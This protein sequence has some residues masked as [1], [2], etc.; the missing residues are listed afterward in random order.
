MLNY[1]KLDHNWLLDFFLQVVNVS[2]PADRYRPLMVY[3]EVVVINF[4]CLYD[5]EGYIRAGDQLIYMAHKLGK[6]KRFLFL[7]EDGA[8]VELSNAIEIIKNIR[9]CFKLTENTCTVICRESLT[10]PNVTVVNREAIPYWRTVCRKHIKHI[11][12]PTPPFSKKFAVWFNRGT[13]YR[14]DI[15]K[16]LVENHKEQSYISYQEPGVLVDR[17]MTE[18]FTEQIDWANA[19]TPIVYDTLWP[20][21]EVD[22][23]KV[24]DKPYDDYFVEIVAE[25]DIRSTAWITEKTVKN[26]CIGKPFILVGA[27]GSLEKIRSLGYETFSP[28][29]DETYDTIVNAYD[30]IEAIKKEIDRLSTVDVN[31]LHDNILPMLERNRK[32]Y[33]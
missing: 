9:D 1:D 11:G 28:W 20:N 5:R 25:T 12:I 31:A 14:L 10:I 17:K 4:D 32:S 33:G 3:D 8:M 21:R 7:S 6:D 19:N 23:T 13:F 29:I 27:P 16:H 30:R 24:L 26:L 15:V 18:Y 22:I 2:N